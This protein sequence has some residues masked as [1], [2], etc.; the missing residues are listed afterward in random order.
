MSEQE[1]SQETEGITAKEKRE[2]RKSWVRVIVT[3]V[4]AAF[5]FVGGG[6]LIVIFGLKCKEDE[7]MNVFNIILPIAAGIV[8]YWFATRSNQKANKNGQTGH[9]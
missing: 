8:T 2:N 6:S 9:A 4:A 7:A 1:P 5:I 3:Y